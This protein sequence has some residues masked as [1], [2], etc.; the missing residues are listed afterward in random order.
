MRGRSGGTFVGLVVLGAEQLLLDDLTDGGEGGRLLVRGIGQ[1]LVVV[2]QSA[3]AI[4]VGRRSLWLAR[5]LRS[6][7]RW[8]LRPVAW[9]RWLGHELLRCLILLLLEA[10]QVVEYAQLVGIVIQRILYLQIWQ[11]K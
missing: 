3:R 5:R 9:Q 10:G 8:S 4:L 6:C 7:L 1:L 2:R 11:L